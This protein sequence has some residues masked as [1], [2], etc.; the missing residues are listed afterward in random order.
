MARNVPLFILHQ[1]GSPLPLHCLWKSS[2][3]AEEIV[4]A[5]TDTITIHE[6]R[7]VDTTSSVCMSPPSTMDIRSRTIGCPRD[8]ACLVLEGAH[9]LFFPLDSAD[10]T[11]QREGLHKKGGIPK[12]SSFLRLASLFATGKYVVGISLYCGCLRGIRLCFATHQ[13][14]RYS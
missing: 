3:S 7:L 4:Q 5:H 10:P 2:T 14:T 1:P 9:A 6:L 8:G 12:F 13:S 11:S